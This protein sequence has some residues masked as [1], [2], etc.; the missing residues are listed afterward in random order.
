VLAHPSAAV[1][2][3]SRSSGVV[4]SATSAQLLMAQKQAWNTYVQQQPAGG[5]GQGL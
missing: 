4:Q 2:R 3:A 1:S 5:G